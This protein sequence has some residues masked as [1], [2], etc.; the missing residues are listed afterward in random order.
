MGYYDEYRRTSWIM[1]KTDK[2]KVIRSV[3][4]Y[5]ISFWQSHFPSEETK[6]EAQL[7]TKIKG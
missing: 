6:T 4:N 3:A 5:L 1:Q 2:S 7:I